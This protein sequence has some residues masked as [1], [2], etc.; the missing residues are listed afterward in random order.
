MTRSGETIQCSHG[1]DGAQHQRDEQK[2]G[3]QSVRVVDQHHPKDHY[4][5]HEAAHS[6][7]DQEPD[8]GLPS[9]R[10]GLRRAVGAASRVWVSP[11]PISS[12]RRYRYAR[13]QPL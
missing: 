11:T 9:G 5:D 3:A 4:R 1:S 6:D 8:F 2:L 12:L 10:K 13:T 7:R